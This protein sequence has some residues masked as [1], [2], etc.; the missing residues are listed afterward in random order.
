M[1]YTT[2]RLINLRASGQPRP[3][4]TE[5]VDRL[6]QSMKEV[7]LIQPIVV[8]P[9]QIISGVAQDGYQI[10]AG[11]HRVAA[12]RA[13]GWEGISAIIID[14]TEHLQAELVEIDE[15][16]MRAEL[17]PAQRAAHVKRRKQI[18]EALH[19]N[20]GTNCPSLGGRGVTSFAAE[21]AEVSG[22]SKRDVNRH[23]ARADALGDDILE[24]VGTSLDKG[25]ELDALA[26][27]PES[28]RKELIERAKAGER[29]SA[30][31]EPPKAA[32]GEGDTLVSWL[33]C[34]AKLVEKMGGMD[35]AVEWAR[36]IHL[37]KSARIGLAFYANLDEV[38]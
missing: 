27:K 16:L 4:I 21:T 19:P 29:V 33:E 10:V 1:R 7:G 15:N 5:A 17:T 13:L 3:L 35:A 9:V 30:R 37:T 26:K 12:A 8:R 36:R 31:T 38:A 6:A 28:E 2:V 23:I 11:H 22:D 32:N 34:T 20:S 25:V 14:S 24:V 18:W